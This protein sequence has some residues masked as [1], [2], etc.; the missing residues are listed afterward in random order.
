MC[1]PAD[2]LGTDKEY[3][4]KI[5]GLRDRLVVPG[6]GSWGQLLEWMHEQHNPQSPELDT[7]HDHHRHTSHL[8]AVYPGTQ[9]SV[10]K[11]PALAAAAKVLLD[12]RGIDAGSDVREWSFAWRTALVC[13]AARRRK[14]AQ[15]AATFFLRA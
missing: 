13:A 14:R 4:D 7:P 6:I 12:A 9:I 3:R 5:A 1:R 10:A 15:H 11:T 8:F 2:A